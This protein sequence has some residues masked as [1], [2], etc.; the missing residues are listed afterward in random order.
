MSRNVVFVARDSAPSRA[1][2]KLEPVLRQSGFNVNL[3]VGDGKPLTETDEEI[4]SAVSGA[5]VVVLGMSS[6]QEL[7]KPEI[8]AGK[9]AKDSDIPY[10]FYGDIRGCWARA[11]VG[12]W[13]E[14]LAPNVAFYFGV[15]QADADAAQEVFPNAQCFGTGN[16][17][18]EEMAFPRF[19]R[20]EVRDRLGVA[21]DEKLIL[22]PG[23]QYTW[24]TLS[25][26]VVVMDALWRLCEHGQRFQLIFTLHPGDRTPYAKD[27]ETG[28]HLEIY[29]HLLAYSPVS[30]RIVDTGE[31]TTSEIVPGAD[32]IVEFGSSIG[33]E[34]AYQRI[35]VVTLGFEPL[36]R[37]F[38]EVGGTRVPEAAGN[39]ISELVM[40]D[41]SRL[42]ETIQRLLTADGFV[43]MRTRQKEL[44]PKPTECGAVLRQMADAIE[45]VI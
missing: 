17:L 27:K 15:T 28:E 8:L 25:Q 33:I 34:A 40:A 26:W 2:I 22:V 36:F 39:G 12:A 19:T 32:V 13:F 29:E 6:S 43:K 37:I 10:G 1:F 35:P 38:E 31:M 41:A 24:I 9:K 21:E 30:A 42:A 18:R 4:V 3:F 20:D 11:R 16:P 44:C 5:N 14:Q 7:A 45:Q 23:A